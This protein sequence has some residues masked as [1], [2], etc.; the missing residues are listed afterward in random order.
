MNYVLG[1]FT[2]FLVAYFMTKMKESKQGY[3]GGGGL[4]N[5]KKGGM[6][7]SQRGGGFGRRGGFGGGRSGGFNRR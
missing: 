1:V 3:S 7:G 4:F 5:K 2:F 6:F